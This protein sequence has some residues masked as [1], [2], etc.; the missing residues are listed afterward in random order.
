M[1]L[2]F[3]SPATPGQ[4]YTSPDG[5]TEWI[6]D[7]IKWTGSTGTGGA[8]L[9]ASSAT[10]HTPYEW[11]AKGDGTTDDT[12][13]FNAMFTALGS[14][15]RIYI[16]ASFYI[17]SAITVPDEVE[18]YGNA[19]PTS[20]Q[21]NWGTSYF[22]APG[23]KLILGA[24]ITLGRACVLRNVMVIAN[25]LPRT[26][27]TNLTQAN[28]LIA[29]M[30]SNG[31]GVTLSRDNC[32]IDSVQILG[33]NI[34]LYAYGPGTG[35]A[36]RHTIRNIHGDN[37]NG[38]WI[39]GT[40][41]TTY[42]LGGQMWPYLTVS[43]GDQNGLTRS[44]RG[45]TTRGNNCCNYITQVTALGYQTDFM[46][47][48]ASVTF[49][50]CWSDGIA[51]A[52]S[53]GY[54]T[55]GNCGIVSLIG[56]TAVAQ[57]FAI[58]HSPSNGA[59]LNLGS[60]CSISASGPGV[61]TTPATGMTIAVYCDGHGPVQAEGVYFGGGA[62]AVFW[63]GPNS[64]QSVVIGNVFDDAAQ[65]IDHVWNV[66]P[67]VLPL[68]TKHSNRVI[69]S[70]RGFTEQTLGTVAMGGVAVYDQMPQALNVGGWLTAQANATVGNNLFVNGAG[71]GTDQNN[72]SFSILG[73]GTGQLVG[74]AWNDPENANNTWLSVTRTGYVPQVITLTA[75]TI[76][77]TGAAHATSLDSTPIGATTP[78]TGAFTNINTTGHL[79]FGTLATGASDLTYG[80][81][82]WPG[83]GINAFS[84]AINVVINGAQQAAFSITGLN[85]AGSYHLSGVQVVGAQIA[86]YGTPT[87]PVKLA[88]FPGAS[89]TLA[90]T[91][92]MVAQL[93]TDLKTHGL[94]GA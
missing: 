26:N 14:G 91:S 16:P 44:G 5:T 94:L 9:P 36:D 56:C 52:N 51:P 15:S 75:P 92:A 48:N 19:S 2:D 37:I 65:N 39:E 13:A 83:Y 78:S 55:I 7:G 67:A 57:Q 87:G 84:A 10:A 93:I 41:D 64:G 85:I 25:N 20:M 66:D 53:A 42:I 50:D 79:S 74:Q 1:P 28:A 3:P 69:N 71:N 73:G 18:I 59:T 32:L 43:C 33:F 21:Y 47:D 4:T 49:V 70:T 34:G 30:A 12:A 61:G 27:P 81:Q 76:T 35:A 38:I 17:A 89:A 63:L 54:A 58:H 62:R 60:G 80:V 22:Q 29:Q 6:F 23:S 82:L 77:L 8:F 40:G 86:G 31:T 72:W 45:V 88:S 68:L 46:T 90:Q 11:G 24:G